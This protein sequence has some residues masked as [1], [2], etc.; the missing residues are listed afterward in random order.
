MQLLEGIKQ[1]LILVIT[2]DP[3][4]MEIIFL[5]LKV[6]GTAILLASL[7][8]IPYGACLGLRNARRVQWQV[9]MVYTCMGF[10]PVVAGLLTYL[11]L[12]SSGPFGVL[13]LLFTPTAMILV[14][15]L[16][17]FPIVTG[18]SMVGIRE[19]DQ[20]LRQTA[21]SLGASPLQAAVIVVKEAR[22]AI[23]GAVV[24]GF[25]RVVAEVGAVMMVGGNIE[26]H[27][28]VMTTAIVLETRKGNFELA[29]GLGL[30]LLLIAFIINSFLYR[31]QN[32]VNKP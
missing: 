7:L 4:L 17:A 32:G 26:G 18:L 14:Q 15:A 16:L 5:S 31:I 27:T 11:L 23:T 6:S 2:L 12:S 22:F 3:D 13:D 28:R 21:I 25:G 8:G 30:V 20:E 19:K 29:I 10:P 24:A 1:A 9:K